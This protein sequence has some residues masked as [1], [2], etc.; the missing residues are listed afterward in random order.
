MSGTV[1]FDAT[2]L[3]TVERV[4]GVSDAVRSAQIEMETEVF[5]IV[6]FFFLVGFAVMGV[7][8]M[9]FNTGRLIKNT[10]P[11]RVRSVAIGRTELRGNARDAGVVFDQPLTGGKC[12]YYSYSIEEEREWKERNDDGKTETKRRWQTVSSETKAAPFL[13]D[14]GTGEILVVANAGADFHISKENSLRE[15]FRGRIPGKYRQTVDTDVDIADALTDDVEWE[16]H[17]LSTKIESKI[18]FLTITGSG[19]RAGVRSSGSPSQPRYSG[20]GRGRVRRRR[21][22]QKVLPV[23]EE[24]YVYG[25]ARQRTDPMG[26]N[27]ERLIVQGDDDT[28]R[29]IVSDKDEGALASKYTRRGLLFVV[30]GLAVSAVTFGVL[31]NELL[32]VLAPPL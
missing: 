18:P 23:D 13:L 26:S 10:S 27:E 4:L 15:T 17:N 19:G 29:F 25:A 28:G 6:V 20:S 11:E 12:L 21:I 7:G 24:V 5:A 32:V 2:V 3:A 22:S 8:A 16:P 9:Q 14:D 31:A 1:R 30:A